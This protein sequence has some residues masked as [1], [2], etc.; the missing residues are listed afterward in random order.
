[1][2]PFFTKAIF[3]HNIP[4]IDGGNPD[5][6]A[7]RL[8]AAG[9]EA[10]YLKAADGGYP[11]TPNRL[12][13]LGWG[14]NVRQEIV[15]ALHAR[16]I[17]VIGWQ[18]NYGYDIA[19]EINIATSQTLRF[20]LDGWIFD[21]ESKFETNAA[22]VS[23]AYALCSGYR[24][25]CPTIPLGFCS[26]AQWRSSTGILWHNENMGKAFMEKCDI[27]LP[28]M[29]WGGSIA[30]NAVW[31]LNESLRLWKNITNKPIIPVGRAYTGDSGY[32]NADAIK[33]FAAEVRAK[34]LP[35]LSWWYLDGAVKDANAWAALASIPGFAPIP[36][37]PPV[38]TLPEL[39]LE[40]KV[41]KLWD[42]HPELHPTIY[43][44][45]LPLVMK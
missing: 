35:G 11:F 15:D 7:D 6:F 33:G 10:V 42:A 31:L 19:T 21:V 27:G 44:V 20:G 24:A 22:A 17:K 4:A 13:Y 9:F 39:T 5:R 18:F 2:N 8:K 16:G 28:M 30:S 29:Y 32:I 41:A 36:E 12:T 3:S 34:Q 25:K 1:M 38:V 37:P 40:E 23:N 14:E 26:W 45:N 43:T